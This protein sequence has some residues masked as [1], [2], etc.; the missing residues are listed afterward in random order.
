MKYLKLILKA[1]KGDETMDYT[2]ISINKALLLLAVPMVVE[3]SFESLF[4]L[5][6][7]FFVAKYVGT[8]GMAT[9]GLTESVLTIIYSLAWGIS[10][11]ATAIIARKI[12]EKN[13]QDASKSLMQIIN[14][15]GGIGIILAAVG[16][17]YS[18]EILKLMGGS[19][20]LIEEGIGYTQIQFLSA[21]IIM[22]LFSLGGA[23]RGAGNASLAMNAMIIANLINMFLDFIFIPI[24]GMG[25]E[26][27]AL[28]TIIGRSVGVA[29]QLSAF[30]TNNI[31]LKLTLKK[32]FAD[33]RLI[34][35]I[36]KISAGSAGQFII[37]SASWVFLIRIL[38]DF[39]SEVV[40]GYTIAIRIIVFTILPSWGLANAAATL[41]GQNLGAKQPERAAKSAW[42]AAFFNMG[43]LGIVAILFFIFARPLVMLFDENPVVMETGVECLQI[44][45][46]GYIFFG[47]GMVM[48]QAING[49]GDTKTPTV[50][51]IIGFW[52]LQIPIAYIL[53]VKLDW[54]Q[55]GVFWAVVISE[56][57][58]A[59]L[60]ILYFKTGRWKKNTIDF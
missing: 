11:A 46:A 60:A 16:F 36:L 28:A 34:F 27:A 33:W 12:G 55:T 1:L 35:E 20:Q 58:L 15:S 40:A 57:I 2:S 54:K 10:T 26:G 53:A 30:F 4:A 37:Q 3:M 7:A 47:F 59:V 13:P 49:S 14:I 45:C 6:D 24:M 38:S 32:W 41:V 8:N 19:D 56:S 51:N 25:V 50:L 18:A 42:R 48:S 29:I 17:Y 43:F 5:V 52:V 31:N 23:L 9:V 44:L 22:L 21:P 39:G